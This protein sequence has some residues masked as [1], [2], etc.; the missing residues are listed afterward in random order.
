MIVLCRI[1]D[2]LI[3]GQVT[4]GWSRFLDIE[5]IVV[6]SD[7]LAGDE[8]QKSFLAMAVPES[9]EFDIGSVV[10]V[11]ERLKDPAYT[12]RRTLLLA[13]SP[14]EFRRLV[15]ECGVK[16]TEINVGG[17]RYADGRHKVCDGVLLT[18]QALEDLVALR[19]A[20]LLVEVRM[21]PSSE[22]K[23]LFK[24]FLEGAAR[25]ERER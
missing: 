16:L 18:D 24:I 17:Q 25:L 14:S 13:A 20:G 5:K 15:L 21:I 6:I 8:I 23:D 10:D 2:R 22:K 9:A 19:D 4:V 7:D 1:D 12:A 3:H 11:A